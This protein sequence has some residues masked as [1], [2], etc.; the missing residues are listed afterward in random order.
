VATRGLN[1]G[2]HDA[3]SGETDLGGSMS[4]DDLVIIPE[5]G[6]LGLIALGSLLGVARRRRR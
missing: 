1:F 4:I 3:T 2:I 5:P 6:S